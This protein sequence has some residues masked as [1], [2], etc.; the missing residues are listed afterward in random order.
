MEGTYDIPR[1]NPYFFMTT[2]P[3]RYSDISFPD[4]ERELTA[5]TFTTPFAHAHTK[6]ARETCRGILSLLS[7]WHLCGR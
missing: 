6:E 2:E 7:H 4:L 5:E 1:K 3:N